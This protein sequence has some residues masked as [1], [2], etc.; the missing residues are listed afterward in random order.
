VQ[1]LKRHG[2]NAQPL[3]PAEASALFECLK[4][5]ARL[6]LAVSGGGDSLALM[7]LITRWTAETP[8]AP[9]LHVLTVDHGLHADSAHVAR[10]VCEQ[11]ACLDLPC[12][13]LHWRG[14]KPRTGIEQAAR[15]ARYALL[16]GWC[17][18]H[19]AALVTAHTLEDQAETFLMRLTRGAGVD[20]LSAMPCQGTVPGTQPPVPLLR[21]LLEV[22]RARLRATLRTLGISWHEDPANADERFERTR[23]RR[24]LPL[25]QEVGITPA[26]IAGSARRLHRA[27]I[28]LDAAANT[29]LQEHASLRPLLWTEISRIAFRSLPEELQLRALARLLGH[30]GGNGAP[31]RDMAALERLLEW[32][33]QE[34]ETRSRTLAGAQLRCRRQGIVIGREPGRPGPPLLLTP[35]TPAGTWDNRY[36]ITINELH[37]PLQVRMLAELPATARQTSHLPPRPGEIPAFVWQAQ[38]ALVHDAH[39]IALPALGWTATAAPFKAAHARPLPPAWKTAT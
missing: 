9:L 5:Y 15:N 12:T 26:A 19:D 25:L 39:I 38:P 17:M 1:G 32:L 21:P 28:A 4:S 35:E 10:Q 14:E 3:S 34:S 6:A 20:G 33:R 13:V 27:R 36:H 22:P 7:H 29:F 37:Q 31:L 24:L 11:A 30:L 2:N 23:L 18:E 16:G 8:G